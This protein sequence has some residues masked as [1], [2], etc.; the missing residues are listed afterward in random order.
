MSIFNR[1]KGV[2]ASPLPTSTRFAPKYAS[3]HSLVANL[4]THHAEKTIKDNI[5]IVKETA[6][7]NED[8]LKNLKKIVDDNLK[9]VVRE[10]NHKNDV[11][12]KQRMLKDK[13]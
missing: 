7:S 3:S 13:L 12:K 10:I 9:K 4:I 5:K 2:A 8:C 1:T 6:K 11:M